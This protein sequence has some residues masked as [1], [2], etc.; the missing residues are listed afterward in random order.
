MLNY[1]CHICFCELKN[2]KSLSNHLRYNSCSNIKKYTHL[3]CKYCN[4]YLPLRKPSE[5]GIFCNRIC[6][7]KW[8]SV[9]CTKEKASAFKHGKC[10]L[11]SL[12]RANKIYRDWVL[13]IFK[14]DNFTCQECGDNKGGNLQAHHICPF[15]KLCRENNINS[16]NDAKNCKK[17]W[18]LTNGKTL[19]IICHKKTE[20][21]GYNKHT[22]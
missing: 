1:K 9:N 13:S 22:K 20:N 12:I 19:C 3:K 15:S 8:R 10:K 2:K 11:H 14:R 21:Y 17:L 18:D 7:G 16:I 4:N 6:Y 5:Q